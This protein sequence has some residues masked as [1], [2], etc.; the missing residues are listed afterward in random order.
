MS[1]N[2]IAVLG[3]NGQLGQTLQQQS[4][5]WAD[6]SL[7]FRFFS[8]Q[9]LDITQTAA[10]QKKLFSKESDFDYIV[11]CAA[12]TAV[13]LAET[14]REK[15]RKV[16]A[17]AVTE[18]ARLCQKNG[19]TL[20]H[21]STDFVFDGKTNTPLTEMVTPNPINHY[22]KSKWLGEEGIKAEMKG[23]FILRTGW[24]YSNYR[25]NFYKTMCRLF[26]GREN[27]SVVYDQVGTPT[28]TPVIADA[29]H[30]IIGSKSTAYGI[31]H[32]ANEGVASWYD[33]AYEILRH[34]DSKCR[35]SPILSKD[36]PTPAERPAYSV[37]D[38]SKFKNEFS[39]AFPHWKESLKE[40]VA[41][42][43][44]L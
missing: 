10:L 42:G 8:A 11:N 22:G 29:I 36:Y 27:L 6:P 15:A 18:I 23:F 31:Y 32:V 4:H 34:T 20:I 40:C 7:N 37:L 26:K 12:Y 1:T 38:K 30:R 44:T 24:L 5:K 14:E 16:N 28:F 3:A 19:S 9:E 43:Q 33:F 41:Q 2:K 13:D 17:T 25:H 35:L 21:I 39:M